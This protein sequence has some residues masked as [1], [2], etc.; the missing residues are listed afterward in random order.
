LI[1]DRLGFFFWNFVILIY[2]NQRLNE[3]ALQ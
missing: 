2:K 3:R 1:F